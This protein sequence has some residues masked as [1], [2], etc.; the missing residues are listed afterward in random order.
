MKL[1]LTLI[2]LM[3]F[4]AGLRGQQ[5]VAIIDVDTLTNMLVQEFKVDS[6]YQSAEVAFKKE[7]SRRARAFQDHYTEV[8]KRIGCASP[9][10][11]KAAKDKLREKQDSLIGFE[12]I[13]TDS[14]PALRAKF[15]TEIR[16][17]IQKEINSFALSGRFDAI[18]TKRNL[19]FFNAEIDKTEEINSLIHHPEAMAVIGKQAN[20]F[21]ATLWNFMK[22]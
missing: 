19:L 13:L 2:F 6:I 16:Q 18:F 14:F 3:N 11:Y 8:E 9:A 10:H 17:N 21:A 7:S 22:N 12:K 1:S 5:K 20:E 4:S 15:L